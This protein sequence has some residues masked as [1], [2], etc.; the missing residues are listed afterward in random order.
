MVLVGPLIV[1]CSE[2]LSTLKPYVC[3]FGWT[4]RGLFRGSV[5]LVIAKAAF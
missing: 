1:A 3:G 2:D 4:V 5:N